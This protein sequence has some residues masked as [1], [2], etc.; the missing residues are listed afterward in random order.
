MELSYVL[1]ALI[2]AEFGLTVRTS[3]AQL[4]VTDYRCVVRWKRRRPEVFRARYLVHPV[5][6]RCYQGVLA[7]LQV[8][9]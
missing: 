3:I 1:C 6:R 9:H 7:G 5:V 2:P 4:V 8:Q